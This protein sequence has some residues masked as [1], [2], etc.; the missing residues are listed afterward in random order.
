MVKIT[1]KGEADEAN[2]IPGPSWNTWNGIRFPRGQP[3][4]ISDPGM[5]T[6]ARQ[7]QFYIVEDETKPVK[8]REKIDEAKD[9]SEKPPQVTLEQ[10]AQELKERLEHK[11]PK[12]AYHY[13][14]AE[15]IEGY[16]PKKK[17]GAKKSSHSGV[18]T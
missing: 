6:S 4:E 13:R 7:N 14:D 10:A 9:K 16:K 12:K 11:E 15:N 5:I 1:W 17:R 8:P 3:V 2:D 18:A